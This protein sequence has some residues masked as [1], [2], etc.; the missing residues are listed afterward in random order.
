[1][2]FVDRYERPLR[3]VLRFASSKALS[4]RLGVKAQI[5]AVRFSLISFGLE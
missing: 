1:M 5:N 2:R 3:I 4:V